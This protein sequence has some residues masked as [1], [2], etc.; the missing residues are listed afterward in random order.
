MPLA[1]SSAAF[2][3]GGQIPERYTR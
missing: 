2:A 1:L 3:E